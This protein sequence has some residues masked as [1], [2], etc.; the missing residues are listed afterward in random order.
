MRGCINELPDD[1]RDLMLAY[2]HGE[3]K[4]EARKLLSTKLGIEMNV[5]R[6]RVCRIR[7]GLQNC[8]G[9]CVKKFV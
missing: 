1:N 7:D 5:L 6:I 4:K 8:V 2:H 3:N 9:K